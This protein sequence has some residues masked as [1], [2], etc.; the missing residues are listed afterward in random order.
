MPFQYFQSI[1]SPQGPV[2]GLLAANSAGQGDRR[3]LNDEKETN[4]DEKNKETNERN[5]SCPVVFM[6]AQIENRKKE[7]F[8]CRSQT[9]VCMSARFRRRQS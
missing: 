8:L 9:V 2:R 4:N 5:I 1:I 6:S 7:Y 3:C